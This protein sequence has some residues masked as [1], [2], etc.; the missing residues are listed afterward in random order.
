MGLKRAEQVIE[1]A[2]KIKSSI[3]NNNLIPNSQEAEVL[4]ESDKLLEV[5][6]PLI[7]KN[8]KIGNDN[9]GK[10]N[11]AEKLV[12]ILGPLLKKETKEELSEKQAVLDAQLTG[13]KSIV[14][15]LIKLTNITRTLL[16]VKEKEDDNLD[17]EE[18]VPRFRE[19]PLK[20][21][22]VPR[23]EGKPL[24]E[25]VRSSGGSRPPKKQSIRKEYDEY[26]IDKEYE[27][28]YEIKDITPRRENGRK[29][30][31]IERV[32]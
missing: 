22:P 5:L 15:A 1:E 13:Q 21:E 25:E 8:S 32:T 23:F 31:L 24:K 29:K 16:E 12:E 6:S 18:P 7:N 2:Q 3:G 30:S 19:R 28:Y 26:E 10:S 14:Q 11:R 17:D 27:D 20:E 9:F 4:T